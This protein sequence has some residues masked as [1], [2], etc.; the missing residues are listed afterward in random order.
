MPLDF[1]RGQRPL[2]LFPHTYLHPWKSIKKLISKVRKSGFNP[3][4]CGHKNYTQ[5]LSHQALDSISGWIHPFSNGYL[6]CTKELT[7]ANTMDKVSQSPWYGSHLINYLIL[8]LNASSNLT[9]SSHPLKIVIHCITPRPP[10][11]GPGEKLLSDLRIRKVNLLLNIQKITKTNR[12]TKKQNKF[13]Q[14]KEVS[15]CFFKILRIF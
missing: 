4:L 8:D 10:H 6:H 3:P 15:L 2:W 7:K 12:Q 5:L 11:K 9:T 14:E 1:G 13:K